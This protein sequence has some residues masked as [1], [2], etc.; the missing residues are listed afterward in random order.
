MVTPLFVSDTSSHAIDRTAVI[1]GGGV[2]GRVRV[3]A[4]KMM[5]GLLIV[6]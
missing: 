5:A 6:I 3:T 2:L 4:G 1:V